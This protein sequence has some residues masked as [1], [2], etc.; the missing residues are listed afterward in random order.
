ML[1][2]TAELCT[3]LRRQRDLRFDGRFVVADLRTLRFCRPS[4]PTRLK[5]KTV[6]YFVS[7]AAATDAGFGPCASCLPQAAP[8]IPEW[9][10]GCSLTQRALRLIDAGYLDSFSVGALA[11]RLGVDARTLDQRL[12]AALGADAA[13]LARMRRLQL[14]HDLL[15]YSLLPIKRVA[16]QAGY[17]GVGQLATAVR[18]S[19]GCTPSALRAGPA[20]LAES[21]QRLRLPLAVRA[22]YH[23]GWVFEFHRRRALGV[24]EQVDDQVLRRRLPGAQPQWLSVSFDDQGAVL[25]VPSAVL[26]EPGALIDLIAQTR[27]VFDL[28]ADSTMVDAALG[29]DDFLGAQVR[30]SPGLRVPGAWN[31]FELAVRAILGQQVSVDRARVLAEALID[32]FGEGDFPNPAQLAD[33]DVSAI[34]MPGQ[35]G[36]AVRAL[37]AAV[38]DGSLRLTD[39]ESPA[40]LVEGLQRLPG[41]GPWTAGYIAMRVGRD[42]DAFPDADW[43]VLKELGCTA[44]KARK[45]AGRWRPWRAYALMYLWAQSSGFGA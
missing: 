41:I 2:L 3:E 44:A 13:S 38:V 32:R 5:Q 39:D 12:Q 6:R 15:W 7:A 34:G 43:V 26:F 8:R 30:R 37:A 18:A 16:L 22:P 23:L 9:S 31:G 33:A 27:R 25:E 20:A 19:F 28:D 14:A 10:L 45:I 35:R 21:R 17:G 40:A 24:L 29:A 11:E 4:C 42:A 36:A 1:P